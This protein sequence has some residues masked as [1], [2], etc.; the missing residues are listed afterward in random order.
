MDSLHP[1]I[2]LWLRQKA[3]GAFSLQKYAHERKQVQRCDPWASS[4]IAKTL[5]NPLKWEWWVLNNPECAEK[6]RDSDYT[7]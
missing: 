4:R 6:E 5:A 2:D 7:A 3:N 1:R